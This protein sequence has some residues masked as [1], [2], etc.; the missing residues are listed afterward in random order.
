MR[1][2]QKR[3]TPLM[4]LSILGLVLVGIVMVLPKQTI[5]EQEALEIAVNAKNPDGSSVFSED[6]RT[7]PKC[8]PQLPTIEN[9][10]VSV[11]YSQFEGKAQWHV[12]V[13]CG[14]LC[15]NGVLINAYSGIVEGFSIS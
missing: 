11:G 10:C 15:G 6:P 14:P 4:I 5:T 8:G 7:L 2:I 13:G 1:K 9:P 12:F 3:L